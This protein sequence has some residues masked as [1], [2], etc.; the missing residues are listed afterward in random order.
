MED[1]RFTTATAAD[2]PAVRT[3]LE[4]CE[5]PVDDLQ[6]AHLE[7]FFVCCLG[8]RLAGHRRHRDHG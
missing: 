7:H 6:A 1:I 3:L 4:R 2:L 8:D 5:L